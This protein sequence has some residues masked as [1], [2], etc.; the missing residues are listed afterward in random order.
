MPS[1]T[2][3]ARSSRSTDARVP[4]ERAIAGSTTSAAWPASSSPGSRRAG[5]D[6]G[7]NARPAAVSG[8]AVRGR[9]CVV[10]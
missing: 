4:S 5:A 8:S 2:S 6:S 10:T 9:S 3:L 7:A 1:F